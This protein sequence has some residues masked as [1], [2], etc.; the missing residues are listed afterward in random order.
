[1]LDIR[2]KEN[3]SKIHTK[4]VKHYKNSIQEEESTQRSESQEEYF[5]STNK[6]NV[7]I[8]TNPQKRY[9]LLYYRQ[10]LTEQKLSKARQEIVEN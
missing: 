10:H 8:G 2:Q 5:E 4:L 1:M 9:E 7:E 3:L 6:K